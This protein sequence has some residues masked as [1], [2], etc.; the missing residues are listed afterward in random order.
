MYSYCCVVSWSST[1][2]EKHKKNNETGG[3]KQITRYPP[4]KVDPMQPGGVSIQMTSTL[5]HQV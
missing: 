3:T 4:A 1:A 2:V 5:V